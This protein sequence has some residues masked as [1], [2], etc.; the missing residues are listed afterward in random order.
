MLLMNLESRPVVFEDIARQVLATGMRRSPKYF[1]DAIGEFLMNLKQIFHIKFNINMQFVSE[2]IS[3]NDIV[4]V[5]QRL[6]ST[7]PSV[8]ARGRLGS[9]RTLKHVRVTY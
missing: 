4:R 9:M 7:P 3:A 1:I 6:L 5:A 2:T 8:A